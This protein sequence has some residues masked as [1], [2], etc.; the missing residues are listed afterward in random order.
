MSN[1]QYSNT[2]KGAI[3]GNDKKTTDNHPDFR[4][5]INIEGV[6]YWLSAWKRGPQAAQNAPSLKFSVQRKEPVEPP[7]YST[8]PQSQQQAPQRQPPQQQAPQQ[9]QQPAPAASG[10]DDFDDD[11]PF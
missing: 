8:A 11:I 4:G 3:W 9:A 10:F 7:Q 6:E 5:S 2:N 1:Q